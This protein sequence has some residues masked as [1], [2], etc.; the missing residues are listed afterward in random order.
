MKVT[1]IVPVYNEEECLSEFINRMT[2]V[3]ED[4]VQ[5]N[6]MLRVLFVDDG[7]TDKSDEILKVVA[8]QDS[9]FQIVQLA[10][11]FGHQSAVWC[12]LE[13]VAQEEVVIVMDCDLQD[14]PEILPEIIHKSKDFDII[15]TRRRTRTD[16]A[17]KRF[18]ASVYY[19]ILNNLSEGNVIQDSGDFYLLKP[20]ARKSLLM[21]KENVKYIRGLIANI[22]FRSFTLE[23]D[24]DGRFAGET[25]YTFTK[26]VRLAIAGVTGSSIKPLVYVSYTALISSAV[27]FAGAVATLVF[28]LSTPEQ[29][30]P[31]IAA[32]ILL[33]LG[34]GS[35]ILISL[36]VISVYLAR[37]TIEIKNRPIY[38]ISE[39]RNL[40]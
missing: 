24:R 26:M 10:T 17:F 15:L 12:G 39:K 30:S 33:S 8:L 2:A 28:K 37:I 36:A 34:I 21:H 7:S 25:H 3:I 35:L 18:T 19:K 1:V 22:G 31:G 29:F 40:E 9:R 27:T 5:F 32:I 14:P 13:T 20:I 4:I 11:N 16:K 6:V 38:L 23:Y